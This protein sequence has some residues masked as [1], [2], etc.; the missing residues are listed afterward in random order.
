MFC[1]RL[2]DQRFTLS[3]LFVKLITRSTDLIL[4]EEFIMY[5]I[6]VSRAEQF[7][8]K[9]FQ[10]ALAVKC[11]FSFASFRECNTFG[12]SLKCSGDSE[13][14]ETCSEN[15]CPVWTEWSEWTACSVTCGGGRRNK[16]HKLWHSV[17]SYLSVYKMSILMV[18]VEILLT[19]H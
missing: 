9:K 14:T 1:P 3:V 10:T 19:L 17:L 8:V 2:Q 11:K 12:S 13:E 15:P 7:A 18:P 4:S 5:N 16:E 6:A